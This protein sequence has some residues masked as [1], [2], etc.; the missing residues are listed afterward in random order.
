MRLQLLLGLMTFSLAC[1]RTDSSRLKM[2]KLDLIAEINSYAA[3]K[4][5]GDQILVERQGQVLSELLN[6]LPA[7]LPEVTAPSEAPETETPAQE[8]SEQT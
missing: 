1:A 2:K 3:A 8:P 4:A 7:E 5:S 6:K